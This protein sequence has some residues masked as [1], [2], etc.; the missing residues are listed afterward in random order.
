MKKK[1][2]IETTRD[3]V[4]PLLD[5]KEREA[6]ADDRIQLT[7]FPFPNLI[8]LNHFFKVNNMCHKLIR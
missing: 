3:Y 2:R 8:K 4:L 6:M 1:R 7:T 5:R